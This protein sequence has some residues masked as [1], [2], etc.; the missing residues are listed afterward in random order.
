MKKPTDKT[1]CIIH[2]LKKTFFCEDC[3]FE[4]CV[5]CKDVHEKGHAIKFIEESAQFVIDKFKM[6]IEQLK[7]LRMKLNEAANQ[8][9]S[10]FQTPEGCINILE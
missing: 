2:K 4:L 6:S 3:C 7:G 5:T 1:L 9:P 10:E 8:D